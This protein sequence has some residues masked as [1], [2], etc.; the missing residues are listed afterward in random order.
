MT[1]A[2][3]P[4]D[5][6]LAD[7]AKE[8]EIVDLMIGIYCRGM[9]HERS[10]GTDK[11]CT[12]CA[13]LRDYTAEKN[14]RCPFLRTGAKTF[15]QFCEVHCYSSQR[16]AHIIEVM[17]YAGPRMLWNRPVYA[18]KHLIAVMKYRKG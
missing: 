14:E 13:D 4:T 2:Q 12:T 7:L 18:V 3:K 5:K 11:L 8:Q 6:Q 17:R 10:V 15:C 16:R 9:K 1:V